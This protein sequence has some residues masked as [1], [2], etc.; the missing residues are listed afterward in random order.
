M[1]VEDLDDRV[2]NREHERQQLAD[3]AAIGL[4]W[5]GEVVRQSERFDLY[6]QAIADLSARSLTYE[7]TC[8]RREIREAAS[9]QHGKAPEAAYPGTC[10]R[11]TAAEQREREAAGRP[12]AV[13]LRAQ[14]DRLNLVD[15]IHGPYE[16]LVD[17]VVLRRNDGVPAYNLA[18]V[19]DDAAQGI[20]EVVRGD[21]LLPSTPRQIHL[22]DL[23]GIERPSYA[24]VPLVLGADGQRMAKRHGAVTLAD[25]TAL[26]ETPEQVVSLLATTLGLAGVG[27][28]VAATDLVERF[29]PDLLPRQPWMFDPDAD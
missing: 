14:V 17:D 13:R 6:H 27:E 3:I 15:R 22:A 2:S 26:G 24:H 19:I 20:E 4:D 1:R 12:A 11:L 23:L 29:D 28:R 18:V 8:T 7:C 25:R 9:A 5:D 16:G 21:D 10:L